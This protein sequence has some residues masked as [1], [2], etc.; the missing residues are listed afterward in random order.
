MN[1]IRW[2]FNTFTTINM[3]HLE[4]LL[5]LRLPIIFSIF[6]QESLASC[7]PNGKVVGSNTENGKLFPSQSGMWP[8]KESVSSWMEINTSSTKSKFHYHFHIALNVR[9]CSRFK[10]TIIVYFLTINHHFHHAKIVTKH[11]PMNVFIYFYINM[12]NRSVKLK[13]KMLLVKYQI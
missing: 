11:F 3:F 2:H 7:P 5:H 12:A 8:I 1:W 4:Y 6:F 10:L 13:R 9:T